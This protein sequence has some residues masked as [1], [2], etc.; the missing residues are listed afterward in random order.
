[1][2]VPGTLGAARR[3]S[4]KWIF[5]DI[6][7]SQGSRTCGIAVGD[8]EPR[9][10]LFGDLG[11]CVA[12]ELSKGS[13]PLNLLIEAPLSVAFNEKGCP[14]GR[15]I[16]KRG[17]SQRYWYLQAGAATLLAATYFLRGLHDTIRARD[18]RPD[19]TIRL[20]EGFASFKQKGAASSHAADIVKLRSIVW[21]ASDSGTIVGCEGLR[22]CGSDTLRSA[23]AAAGM[24]FGIP[25]VVVVD[26]CA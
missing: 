2:I 8:S 12:E 5:V 1:M 10:V 25:P 9:A 16:E 22:M 24:D 19:R 7:F 23:F 15:K 21:G 4:G 3:D 17:S 26:E 20:F 11:A 14:A 13:G 6:G 18:K